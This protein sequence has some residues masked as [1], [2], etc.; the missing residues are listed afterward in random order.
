MKLLQDYASPLPGLLKD[1]RLRE[2]ESYRLMHFVVQLPVDEGL[3]LY[4]VMTRAVA[5]LSSEA[6]RKVPD[7]PA[8][9][10]ELV[11]RWFAVPL[12]HDDRK[13]AREVRAVGRMLEKRPEGITGFTI[14]TTTDCNARCF[15]CYEKGRSRISMKEETA[16][17]VAEFIIRNHAT[18]KV[19]LLWFG[20]EP[21]YNKGVISLICDK[22]RRAG[23]DYQSSM[24]SNGYLF[25]DDTV[26]EA[27]GPWNLKRV[28]ITL[29]GTEEV[30]NRSKAF[31]R[32]E[33]SPYRRVLSNIHCLLDAGIQ[34]SIRLNIGRHNADDL[35]D[36]ADIL[37]HEFG[38]Q[39]LL[40]V[41][42]HTLFETGSEMEAVSQHR[43]LFDARMKLQEKLREGK[44]A[45]E[46]SLPDQLKLNR[47]MADRDAD[48][49]ILPDGRLGQCEHYSEDPCFGSIDSPER[50]ETLLEEF[51][52]LREELDA[53]ADCPFYPDCYRLTQCEEAA[54]CYPEE[55]EE[56]RLT[57]LRNLSDFYQKKKD[58]VS[59]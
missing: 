1:Q 48:V 32:P 50:D 30:Y 14:L 37:T 3:L 25:D 17:K 45:Q 49:I 46:G 5:L 15:Y 21:L 10:P 53:C 19:K 55:R 39:K 40:G 47:C 4:N 43:E 6:A 31:V 51:K 12:N 54:H 13:L 58:E 29:D 41:Y 8:S 34:V 33:T 57:T 23:V 35:L 52:R 20:G 44:F 27:I 42:S 16:L 2:G 36:L 24:I 22:L 28:Q 9:V 59:D 56:K 18:G 26:S 7:N 11:S 38:G